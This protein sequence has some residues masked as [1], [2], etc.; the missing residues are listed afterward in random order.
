MLL[1]T[2]QQQTADNTEGHVLAQWFVDSKMK[3]WLIIWWTK[4]F[5]FH[6][7]HCSSW[8]IL[9]DLHRA[10]WHSFA[11]FK[12]RQI[13]VL[14]TWL[15]FILHAG[16]H[17]NCRCSPVSVC[18]GKSL[19]LPTCLHLYQCPTN[20]NRRDP[21]ESLYLG[22]LLYDCSIFTGWEQMCVVDLKSVWVENSPT[23]TFP[24][25]IHL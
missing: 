14:E 25:I 18:L 19:Q 24:G 23:H 11:L 21:G 1:T 17:L 9:S 12:R 4:S 5:Y 7:C 10:V 16:L 8:V 15:S 3:S 13:G 6:H 22:Y 20:F 2:H